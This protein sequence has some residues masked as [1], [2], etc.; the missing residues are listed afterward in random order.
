MSNF[1]D[2]FFDDNNPYAA[3]NFSEGGGGPG[4][5]TPVQVPDYF[6]ASIL[7]T[8]FCCLPF[9]IA[10]I[11]FASKAKSLLSIGD[12]AGALEQGKK[13]KLYTLWGFGLGLLINLIAVALQFI[14]TMAEINN[15]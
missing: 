13:A 6:V 9:G 5:G 12:Y 3:S 1:D 10:G 14:M 2:Q 8:L 15:L 11:V 4:G 7:V